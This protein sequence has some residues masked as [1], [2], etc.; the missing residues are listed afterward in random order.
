MIFHKSINGFHVNT[1]K[2]VPILLNE[3]KVCN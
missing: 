3:T 1:I 2:I